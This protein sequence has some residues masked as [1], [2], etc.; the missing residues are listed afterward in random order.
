MFQRGSMQCAM[1]CMYAHVITSPVSDSTVLSMK[2]WL[3]IVLFDSLI[4]HLNL[5][6]NTG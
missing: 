2:G 5:E 4:D 6:V 1:G 3:C